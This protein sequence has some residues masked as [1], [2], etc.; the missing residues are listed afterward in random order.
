MSEKPDSATSRK[1]Q[2]N[3]DIAGIFELLWS[4]SF[5]ESWFRWVE[6]LLVTSGL[7]AL[8]KFADSPLLELMAY[9][10]GAITFWY[11]LHKLDSTF[12]RLARLTRSLR[13]WLQIAASLVLLVVMAFC[14]IL[15]YQAL[16]TVL[17][18][19]IAD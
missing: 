18:S 3:P 11:A 19:T 13:V 16:G 10:S 6:W 14:A 1:P 12:S 4:N 7:Y 8:G 17:S 15:V 9:V 2:K 5:A